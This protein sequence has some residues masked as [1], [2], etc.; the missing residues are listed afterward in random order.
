MATGNS[1]EYRTLLSELGYD[2]EDV[3]PGFVRGETLRSKNSGDGL[4]DRRF[5]YASILDPKKLGV[6]DVFE[7]NGAP[8]IYM[9]VLLPIRARMKSGAGTEP[10]GITVWGECFGS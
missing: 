9:R 1:Q 4:D 10:L 7:I 5:R 8:C 3:D 6:T 2:T